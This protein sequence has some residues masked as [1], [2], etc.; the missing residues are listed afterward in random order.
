MTDLRPRILHALRRGPL[1]GVEIAE[2]VGAKVREIRP[3]VAALC[4]RGDITTTGY[5]DRHHDRLLR[6]TDAGRERLASGGE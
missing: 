5:S 2:Q 6:L 4:E 3:L 1:T